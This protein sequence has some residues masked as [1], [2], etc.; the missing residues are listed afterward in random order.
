MQPTV[1][2]YDYEYALDEDVE[3]EEEDYDYEYDQP[4]VK[5]EVEVEALPQQQQQQQYHLQQ[6][7]QYH[8]QQQQQVIQQQEQQLK[9]YYE[10]KAAA[11]GQKILELQTNYEEA[12]KRLS[13]AEQ[14]I[15]SLKN[16]KSKN[17]VAR[18][19]IKKLEER[20]ELI[21]SKAK[22]KIEEKDGIIGEL[23]T[24]LK[25]Y[26]EML[27]VLE[28][29]CKEAVVKFNAF[30]QEIA[31]KEEV[32]LRQ[33]AFKNRY[34]FTVNYLTEKCQYITDQ[35]ELRIK[36]LEAKLENNESQTQKFSNTVPGP[37]DSKLNPNLLVPVDCKQ[38]INL[39][40]DGSSLV[41]QDS[42]ASKEDLV[43]TAVIEIEDPSA[44]TDKI[45]LTETIQEL[46]TTEPM[47]Q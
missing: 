3:I 24:K 16:R 15:T 34:D 19:E 7:Q 20:V 12:T 25:N 9:T 18:E 44:D 1:M 31:K 35:Y 30:Q 39:P 36:A 22:E 41:N 11:D 43:E 27:A 37:E 17:N 38:N 45:T 40:S 32:I 28:V 26:E 2:E 8:L 5:Q 23:S 10:S 46:E 4:D 33:N 29:Q 6:Q 42:S 14:E 21:K 13:A 47:V